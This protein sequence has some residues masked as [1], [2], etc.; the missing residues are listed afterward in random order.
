MQIAID[1]AVETGFE[2]VEFWSDTRFQR[3]HRFFEKF[4]FQRSGEVR[5]MNDSHQEYQ[6]YFYFLDLN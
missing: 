5:T 1:W 4:G 6:E 3:A 2:R